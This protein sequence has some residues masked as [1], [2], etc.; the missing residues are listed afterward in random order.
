MTM[1]E[2]KMK[3]ALKKYINE[4]LKKA[5][6]NRDRHGQDQAY[7]SGKVNAFLL[8]AGFIDEEFN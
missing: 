2:Y 3:L 6:E 8:V 5:R 4:E 1:S 7:F